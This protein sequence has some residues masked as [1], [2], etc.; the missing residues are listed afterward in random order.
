MIENKSQFSIIAEN[1]SRASGHARKM[2]EL[3]DQLTKSLSEE[4]KNRFIN[5]KTVAVSTILSIIL[6]ALVAWSWFI[7]VQEGTKI[8][9]MRVR[10][11]KAAYKQL[12]EGVKKISKGHLNLS[13]KK[14]DPYTAEISES[15]NEMLS[16]FMK[17]IGEINDYTTKGELAAKQIKNV[18]QVLDKGIR[19]IREKFINNQASINAF[20]AK[21]ESFGQAYENLPKKLNEQQELTNSMIKGVSKNHSLASELTSNAREISERFKTNSE[22]AQSIQGNV[23][24]INKVVEKANS[25]LFNMQ[26]SVPQEQQY[27][28]NEIRVM[29]DSLVSN[30][31]SLTSTSDILVESSGGN[32]TVIEDMRDRILQLNEVAQT[33][34][35]MGEEL[36]NGNEELS[37][38]IQRFKTSTDAM[39]STI[40]DISSGTEETKAMLDSQYESQKQT[41]DSVL[42]IT[43]TMSQMKNALSHLK[44]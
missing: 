37:S 6:M 22:L 43:D 14:S 41:Y 24:D 13:L 26:I 40:D 11:E 35:D 3:S 29:I 17:I 5:P 31:N 28:L 23:K 38:L 30:A 20:M 4:H 9:R 27:E 16:S 2:N 12:M 33:A 44:V 32:Q 36:I 8:D 15:L 10:A 42:A 25:A 39:T 18:E 34:S 7:F 19:V 21:Y 1:F